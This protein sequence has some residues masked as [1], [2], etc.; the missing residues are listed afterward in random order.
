M[1]LFYRQQRGAAINLFN[2]L[3]QSTCS[4]TQYNPI[5]RISILASPAFLAATTAMLVS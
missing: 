4:T 3:N 2:P 5:D 1:R